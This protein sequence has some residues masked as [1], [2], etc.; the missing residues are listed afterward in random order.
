MKRVFSILA[1]TGIA[2]ATFAH[3][4]EGKVIRIATDNTD[5]VL[6]VEPM[7]DCIKPILAPDC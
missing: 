6:K 3:P 7:A 5:L 1:T 2:L 4:D